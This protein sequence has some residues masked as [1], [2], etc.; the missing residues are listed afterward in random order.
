M[1]SRINMG[2]GDLK[3]RLLNK[4]ITRAQYDQ[5]IKKIGYEYR[6]CLM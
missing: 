2:E 4:E 3:K 6:L 5:G 1:N